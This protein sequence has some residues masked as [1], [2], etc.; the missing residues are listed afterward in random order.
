MVIHFIYIFY[1]IY[2]RSV[3]YNFYDVECC[4]HQFLFN[5]QGYKQ[6]KVSASLENHE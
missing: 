1:L 6:Q 3:A 5:K 4:P 2:T